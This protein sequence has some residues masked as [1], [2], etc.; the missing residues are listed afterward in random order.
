M[1]FYYA[2]NSNTTGNFYS[3]LKNFYPTINKWT[4]NKV[5][6]TLDSDWDKKYI[7]LFVYGNLCNQG[8]FYVDNLVIN[9][10]V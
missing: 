5:T 3:G 8:E 9:E 10:E 7:G 4:T 1:G 2:K 6:I